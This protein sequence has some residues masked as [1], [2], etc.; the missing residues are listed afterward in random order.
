[1]LNLWQ[2]NHL[3]R[4]AEQL[5]Q[6]LREPGAAVLAPETVVVPNFGMA[7][8]FSLEVAARVGVSAN[9]RFQLPAE[10]VWDIARTA[11]G[12]LPARSAYDPEILPWRVMRRLANPARGSAFRPVQA[13]V[14]NGGDLRR[15][16]LAVRIARVFD[17]Y[18]IYRPDWLRRWEEG[19][20]DHWQAVL[21]RELVAETPEPHW[22]RIQRA[23]LAALGRGAAATARLPRRVM[24]FG[25]SALSPGYLE[26]VAALAR[27]VDVH[28]FQMNPCRQYWGDI[29]SERAIARARS[30]GSER[31]LYAE[32][33]NSLFASLGVQA[34]DYFDMLIECAPR[35][36]DLFEAPGETSLLRCLQSDILD[37]RERGRG[38]AP[39]VAR[40]ADDDSIQIHVCHSP[41][42][43][44]EVLHDQLLALFQRR[45][46]LTP[47]DV[48]VL[49]PNIADYA[50]YIEAVFATAPRA[51]YLPFSLT[52]RGLN[53]VSPVVAGFLSF[54]DIV[55]SRLDANGVLTLLET[56]AVQRRF[57]LGERDL[58]LIHRWVRDS[59]IRWGVDAQARADLGL[60]AYA[61]N[62]WRAGLDRLLLGYALPGE[63]RRLFA[64][65]LPYDDIEGGNAQVLGRFQTF[66]ERLFEF[67]RRL[68]S[69]RSPADW[70]ALLGNLLDIFF[71]PDEA[72]EADAQAV[73]Q[74]MGELA[75]AAQQG[76]FVQPVSLD[77]V[78]ADVRGRLEGRVGGGRY[79]AGGVTFA[80]LV[81]MRCT[82]FKVVCLI[83]MNDG[84][85]PRVHHP[86][87]FDRMA[88]DFRRGDRP[89]RADDRYL[90]LEA[91]LSARAVLYLS[92]VGQSIRDNSPIPPAVVVSELTDYLKQA[93][94]P[95]Q[96]PEL[97]AE[98]VTH[99]PLQAFSRRYFTGNPRLPSFSQELC[100]A[101]RAAADVRRDPQPLFGERLPAPE[102]EWRTVSLVQLVRFFRHPTRYLLQQR[103]RIR[104]EE[105]EGLIETREPFELDHLERFLLRGRLL[106][107]RLAGDSPEL[108]LP[109]VRASGVVPVGEVGSCVLQREAA[110]AERLAA[111]VQQLAVGPPRHPLPVDL[112]VGGMHLVGTLTQLFEAGRVAHKVGTLRA[113]DQLEGWIN[114]LVLNAVAPADVA[115][116][117]LLVDEDDV[118]AFE[119]V[120]DAHARLQ[121]LLTLYWEGLQRPLPLF[122]QTSHAFVEK[123][124]THA[125]KAWHGNDYQSGE[126]EDPYLK[127]VFRG[128]DPRDEEF[129]QLA[130][131]IFGP[132]QAAQEP[133]P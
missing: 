7:R 14:A 44:V 63:E 28:L 128:S 83:G 40:R 123:G 35:E 4:L 5:A 110:A 105:S 80:G 33:G 115:P 21:W 98:I 62:T 61:Q 91:I 54:L 48:V 126:C 85:F 114:H 133:R 74:A 73:R 32:S 34:R 66:V 29:R 130:Q 55:G 129:E 131:Q 96:A 9:H 67:E 18:L 56:R 57:D 46:T 68:R 71:D 113:A 58:A 8:W 81:P 125:D 1:V 76:G 30:D 13:Y 112:R 22:A 20:E 41:M 27:A 103:M 99:H 97:L 132:M 60:P 116:K 10:F 64:D 31:A 6:V 92:Y 107:A 104:L 12:D 59:G 36:H 15:Y 2:S 100:D 26:V 38:E 89:R 52:D 121:K 42:R 23:L 102:A 118:V 43:E 47:S 120:A 37:L 106:A 93:F 108:V 127:L 90:F 39:A 49:T 69:P 3:E 82:P 25:I 16:E 88:D 70:E 75:Q 77:V 124:G 122:P 51:R 94:R 101:S 17:Q 11:L 50:P 95:A 109:A 78:K 117:S 119:A 72:E 65:V 79:L 84:A 24:L 53:I 111:R 87:G 19:E 45:P 86:P